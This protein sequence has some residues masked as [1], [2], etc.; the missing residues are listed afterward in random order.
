MKPL[1]VLLLFFIYLSNKNYQTG[2]FSF[3]EE[4]ESYS[5]CSA[6]D[7]GSELNVLDQSHWINEISQQSTLIPYSKIFYTYIFEPL[8]DNDQPNERNSAF[9]GFLLNKVTFAICL[10]IW[11]CILFIAC[12]TVA[13]TYI[14]SLM[15]KL[16]ECLSLSDTFAGSTLLA[17]SNA[18]SDVILGIISVSIGEK[19]AIDVFLGDVIGACLFIILVVFGCVMVSSKSNENSNYINIP[20]FNHLRDTIALTIGLIQLLIINHL[21]FISSKMSVI[22]LIAYGFYVLLLQWSEKSASLSM[23]VNLTIKEE[24]VGPVYEQITDSDE[25]RGGSKLSLRNVATTGDFPNYRSSNTIPSVLPIPFTPPDSIR[26]VQRVDYGNTPDLEI[27]PIKLSFPNLQFS[28]DEKSQLLEKG[29][30]I[31]SDVYWDRIGSK[32]RS[33]KKTLL[34]LTPTQSPS[35]SLTNDDLSGRVLTPSSNHGFGKD[36]E[37]FEKAYGVSNAPSS[38]IAASQ[39]NSF[40]NPPNRE[41]NYANTLELPNPW[42]AQSQRSKSPV[43]SQ[44][45]LSQNKTDQSSQIGNINS[46]TISDALQSNNFS[47]TSSSSSSSN[48]GSNLIPN[49]ENNRSSSHSQLVLV[50]D[51]Y[52]VR[53]SRNLSMSEVVYQTESLH[54]SLL[55]PPA[56]EENVLKLQKRGRPRIRENR[57]IIE[58][59][60]HFPTLQLKIPQS[61]ERSEGFFQGMSFNTDFESLLDGFFEFCDFIRQ[62]LMT[63][64][65]FVLYLTVP[66]PSLRRSVQIMQPLFIVL[67]VGFEKKIYASHPLFYL[68]ALLLSSIISL[69]LFFVYTC[70]LNTRKDD[71]ADNEDLGGDPQ[72]CRLSRVRS[73]SNIKLPEVKLSVNTRKLITDLLMYCDMFFGISMSIYWNG[74]LVNELVECIR[75]IGLT[76][77]IKPAILGLTIVAMGNSIADLFANVA[78]SRA[79][80]AHMGLAGCYGACVFLLLFGFGSSV[81]VRAIQLG[82][83]KDIHLHFESQIITAT[84]Q[85]LY[86]LPISA[87]VVVLSKGRVHRIWGLVFIL[88]FIVCMSY[89]LKGAI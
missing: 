11:S 25:V 8:F 68:I 12:G 2:G 70:I 45:S 57:H 47:A 20:I 66:S 3:P 54:N 72:T 21:G 80:H 42:N 67:A 52:A 86:F 30:V 65:M 82:F 77:G 46:M 76:L 41:R 78:V 81:F 31:N 27:P 9:F 35:P 15:I 60:A 4:C 63:P 58:G 75:V 49:Y 16:A 38:R 74:V 89:I 51:D 32:S 64:I 85:L 26:D 69:V 37:D 6:D 23:P 1:F 50:S 14:S 84:Y 17:F 10:L 56:H 22:P 79:G 55:P 19:D 33:I 18:A 53:L 28:Y 13:D 62:L 61:N 71:Q 59:R 73:F 7:H 83:S 29:T 48:L 39:R 88:Y 36:N 24:Y 44:L 34:L 40:R 5:S 87:L 43:Y